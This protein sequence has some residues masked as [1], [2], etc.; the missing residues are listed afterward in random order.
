MATSKQKGNKER[1]LTIKEKAFCREYVKTGNGRDSAIKAGYAEK[2]AHVTANKL[3]NKTYIKNEI[4][5]LMEKKETKAI[6]DGQEVMEWFTKIARGE[7]KDQFGLDASLNDRLKAFQELAKRT[8]DI[9][10]KIEMNKQG[11]ADN[12][13]SIK[14]DWSR[15]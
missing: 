10:K 11:I 8:I 7:V 6:M 5:R 4:T 2:S 1:P 15:D 12:T 14:I 9:D 13:I 3:L